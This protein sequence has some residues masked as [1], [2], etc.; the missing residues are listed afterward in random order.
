M[1]TPPFFH[2]AFTADFF[3]P[4]GRPKYRDLGTTLLTAAQHVQVDRLREFHPVIQAEQLRDIHG[5]VELAPRVTAD[6]L[7]QADQL[8]AI[9]RFGV[10]YDSVDVEACTAADVLL[11]IT[12]GAVDRPVAEATVGW[13]L[14][15]THHLR[16]KDRLVR[17]A[18]WSER[19][20]Y[21][22]CELRERTLGIIGFGGIGRAVIRLLSTFDMRPPLVFDPYV[23][24]AVVAQH[25]AQSVSLDELLSTADFVSLHCP[26][27][28]ETRMLI[29]RREL[30]LMRPTAYLINTARGGIVDEAALFEALRDQRIAG[31]AIDCFDGEPLTAPPRLAELDNVLLAPHCIAWTEELFRDIGRMVCQGMLD[32]ASG[33]LPRAVVNPAVLAR[34]SFQAKWRRIVPSVEWSSPTERP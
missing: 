14:A 22:G 11:F 29:G 24:P 25:G 17:E 30:A 28:A 18:R 19:S 20:R 4:D 31:A 16:I 21:M 23:D 32:V 9:G 6:S 3:E 12:A 33:R 26:L 34:P 27:T 5:V 1:T 10:G 8:L 2:V 15:L 7:R 13:M